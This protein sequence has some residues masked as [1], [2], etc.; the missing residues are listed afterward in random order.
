MKF[1]TFSEDCFCLSKLCRPH[2]LPKYCKS[3]NFCK[4]FIFA[5]SV[6]RHICDVKNSRL[7]HD[8]PISVNNR[9]I[10]PFHED[11]IFT[12]LRIYAYIYA[13]FHEKKTLAKISELGVPSFVK[14]I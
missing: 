13:K 9:V 11:S 12:K 7:E 10:L 3:G 8:L 2:C 4:N 5:N 1:L 14:V 6:K